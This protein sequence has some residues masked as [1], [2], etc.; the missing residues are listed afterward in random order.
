[1]FQTLLKKIANAFQAHNIP[2]MIIGGQAVLL[3][4]EPRLTK[5]IDV[6]LGVGVDNLNDIQSVAEFLQL[7]SLTADTE[8]FVKETMVMPVV[9]E[10][11]GIRV[12]FIFSFSPYERHAIERANDILIEGTPVK[13]ATL[14]DVIIQKIIAGRAR[15]KEDAKSILLKNPY[16]DGKYIRYWLGEFDKALDENYS[17][18]FNTLIEEIKTDI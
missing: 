14:E 18:L 5:D 16:Y 17:G 6:T 7:K 4:G 8:E 3:Y 12:D 10:S 1:M 13:F 9:E 11:S 15:D 2:Y